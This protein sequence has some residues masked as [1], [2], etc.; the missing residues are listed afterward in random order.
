MMHETGIM[1]FTCIRFLYIVDSPSPVHREREKMSM[2][3]RLF[4]SSLPRIFGI[5]L[6]AIS[7]AFAANVLTDTDSRA[8]TKVTAYAGGGARGISVE[9]FRPKDIF[10]HA[11]DSIEWVNPYE[12]IH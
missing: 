10:I 4:R 3:K 8:A 1:N 7:A 2:I 6:L 12:E 9:M 5:G 11:G